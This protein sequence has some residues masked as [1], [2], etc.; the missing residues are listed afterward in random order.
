MPFDPAIRQIIA[1]FRQSPQWN[2]DLDLRLLQAFWPKLVG[3][4]LAEST[5]V[6]E[7]RGSRIIVRVPDRTWK[8]QLISLRGWMLNKVNEPWPNRW[9]TDIEFT[10]EDKRN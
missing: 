6:V 7:V 4:P 1:S 9:I 2:E 10:Y 3:N 8:Q 5:S